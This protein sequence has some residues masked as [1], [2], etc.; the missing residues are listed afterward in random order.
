MADGNTVSHGCMCP[1]AL[2]VLTQV[3]LHHHRP[4]LHHRLYA[5]R[6]AAS[7]GRWLG[8]RHCPCIL[9]AVKG[10]T[11]M[12]AKA[13]CP[14]FRAGQGTV[15]MPSTLSLA[16]KLLLPGEIRGCC[17]AVSP[18]PQKAAHAVLLDV[19]GCMP[20]NFARYHSLPYPAPV[21][22]GRPASHVRFGLVRCL[23][24]HGRNSYQRR[25]LRTSSHFS[26]PLL[27]IPPRPP[28]GVRTQRW[29][30]P[31]GH[32]VGAVRGAHH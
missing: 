26:R 16:P 25:R 15:Y 21:V 2:L 12:S 28:A 19:V 4:H 23:G 24:L 20:S 3:V 18:S 14:S 30:V 8:Y 32:A 31:G 9:Y 10:L 29:A 11:S 7:R 1:V 5:L 17:P 22:T 27:A 13:T 6:Y